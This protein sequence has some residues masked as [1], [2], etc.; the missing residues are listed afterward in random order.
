MDRIKLNIKYRPLW[1]SNANFF[2]VTGGRGSGKSFAVADFLENLTFE[3]G[4]TILFTR[5]T[6]TSAHISIIPEFQ[7]KI[8]LE[9]HEAYF[10]ITKT[11]IE[12][13]VT[14]SKIIFRG[15]KTSSG[16]QTAN[17]KSIQNTTTW[18]LDEA[19]ELTDEKTFDTIDESIRKV[20]IHNRVI[21]L[22]N[23]TTKEHFIYKR[24]FEQMGV[25][26]GFCGEVGNV[27]YIH[28]TY[29]DNIK[30]LS[31][32]FINKVKS[33]MKTNYDKYVH[34]I[35][36][37]WLDA[38]EG[39]IFDNWEYGAFDESLPYMHG[40]DFGYFPDPDVMTKV[41]IDRKRKIIYVKKLCSGNNQGVDT[42]AEQIKV[43]SDINV[44]TIADS[45]EKRLIEDLKKRGIVNIKP[46]TKYAGSVVAGIK[47]MLDYKF[48]VHPDS[49]EIGT[50]FNNYIWH[51]KKNGVPRDAFNHYIDSIR[52]VVQTQLGKP[53]KKRMKIASI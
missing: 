47:L 48:M 17:L 29:L 43:N 35:L 10:N 2:I 8:T 42:L 28:T 34:R 53:A 15:I 32:K 52:Y 31:E 22:M 38:A 30:N 14:E 6:L 24:F 5:Y 7:E 3:Q 18:V 21:I 36:G 16:N 50:E 4:H 25:K 12:N 1:T 19:E 27:C 41:A 37:G 13:I 49:T 45:A 40:L 39:V 20:G 33:L 26:E 44:T 46:V 9:N 51:D 23:P 11:E